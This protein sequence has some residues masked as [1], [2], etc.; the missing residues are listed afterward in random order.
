MWPKIVDTL[1]KVVLNPRK[2]NRYNPIWVFLKEE[3]FL[4]DFPLERGRPLEPFPLLLLYIIA[5]IFY[6]VILFSL[7]HSSLLVLQ[8]TIILF[9]I[10]MV[11]GSVNLTLGFINIFILG[12]FN[13]LDLLSSTMPDLWLNATTLWG[14]IAMSILLITPHYLPNL[15]NSKHKFWSWSLIYSLFIGTAVFI[16]N[17]NQGKLPET[18]FWA[19]L[20]VGSLASL[21]PSIIVKDGETK[22]EI[23]ETVGW[24]AGLAYGLGSIILSW[25]LYP[26]LFSPREPAWFNTLVH[27]A[28]TLLLLLLPVIVVI[29]VLLL[30]TEL[31]QSYVLPTRRWLLFLSFSVLILI[32]PSVPAALII[33]S[34]IVCFYTVMFPPFIKLFQKPTSWY[35]E[36]ASNIFTAF[37]TTTIAI[38]MISGGFSILSGYFIVNVPAE[39]ISNPLPIF[40]VMAF[41]FTLSGLHWS[42]FVTAIAAGISILLFTDLPTGVTIWPIVFALVGAVIIGSSRILLWPLLSLLMIL[43]SR[44]IAMATIWSNSTYLTVINLLETDCWPYPLGRKRV[45]KN[46]AR[47]G[48]PEEFFTRSSLKDRYE[49]TR[50]ESL[51]GDIRTASSLT[52]IAQIDQNLITPTLQVS[53]EEIRQIQAAKP[54]IPVSEKIRQYASI[55]ETAQ[56]IIKTGPRQYANPQIT[57][58][59]IQ[60][61]THIVN[62]IYRQLRPEVT[63]YWRLYNEFPQVSI[64]KSKPSVQKETKQTQIISTTRF[65]LEQIRDLDKSIRLIAPLLPFLSLKEQE[66]YDTLLAIQPRLERFEQDLNYQ[67]RANLLEEIHNTVTN[68]PPSI[69]LTIDSEKDELRKQDNPWGAIIKTA[70][71]YLNQLSLLNNEYIQWALNEIA[72]TLNSI[73]SIESLPSLAQE[74]KHVVSFGEQYGPMIDTTI[75]SLER[76]SREAN[77]ALAFPTGYNR[78]L[79]LQETHDQITKLRQQL[80]LRFV[81]EAVPISDPLLKLG[82]MIHSELFAVSDNPVNAY[83]NPYIPGNP[84]NLQ[85]AQLFKGREDLAQ[86]IVNLLRSQ[87]RP[88]LVLHG[89][90]RMGKT[91]FLLQLPRLLPGSY[92]PIYLD[93]Q[94]AGAQASDEEFTYALA[95][96]IYDQI[97]RNYRVTEPDFDSFEKRPFTALTHWLNKV[98]PLLEDKILLFTIDEFE[99]IGRAIEQ[100]DLSIKVL[101]YLRHLMQHNSNMILM[102]A[103]VQTIDA[104]GPDPASY[105]IS[106]YPIEI[107]YL[108]PKEAEELIRHPDPKAG[109]MPDYDDEVV[110]KILEET[111]CQPLL[112]QFICSEIINLANEQNLRTINLQTLQ[113]AITRVLGAT[114]YFDNIWVD[115]GEEGQQLL[116]KLANGP[117]HPDVH[118]FSAEIIKDLQQR[119]VIRSLPNDLYEIEIP[120]IRAWIK[121]K[122]VPGS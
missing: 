41:I 119:R 65:Y 9:G 47:R 91:S 52:D 94:D 21:T 30:D 81:T 54:P 20:V 26:L 28:I 48:Y 122:M 74:T 76:I 36:T 31:K 37:I 108:H 83:L 113:M 66:V 57:N 79:G 4:S 100:K 32:T 2:T 39:I 89:P 109:T 121:R 18:Y 84:L 72:T 98:T 118:Q 58:E 62:I 6:A 43:Q 88:T 70:K 101:D 75:I 1:E 86:K 24:I 14:V 29:S 114:L 27:I 102:F 120:L 71:H 99:I 67:G 50:I 17:L 8:Q 111:L 69:W 22:K 56:G 11:L 59:E 46:L 40:I 33:A 7:G 112:V 13:I 44:Q 90:R 19:A 82:E 49:K 23:K 63:E 10:C 107:S 104:L 16:I 110:E 87:S 103:G 85:S 97:G 42:T 61:L 73:S 38:L 15:S 34:L 12:F 116:M 92:L 55:V 68:F 105:F 78:R 117:I 95:I 25:Q 5:A 51:S 53:I 77:S 115:A 96:A 64:K 45:L 80:A 3:F 60:S 35:G 93:M 106:A